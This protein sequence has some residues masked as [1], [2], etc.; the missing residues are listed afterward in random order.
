MALI[1]CPECNKEVSDT[2]KN[3][4]H[5]GYM[6]SDTEKTSFTVEVKKTHISE[7]K[8]EFSKGAAFIVVGIFASLFSLLILPIGLISLIGG[9]MFITIGAQKC[10]YHE[11]ICPYC[12]KHGTITKN[13]TTYYCSICGKCSVRDNDILKAIDATD[14]I[15]K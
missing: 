11:V 7:L 1:N 13:A 2:A 8:R 10:G 14:K 5:C 12:G 6:L 4:P 9:I 15:H 3:C